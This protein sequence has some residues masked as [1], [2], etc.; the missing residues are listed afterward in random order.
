MSIYYI[1][2]IF[3]LISI[4]LFYIF[5]RKLVT[6]TKSMLD[7]NKLNYDANNICYCHPFSYAVTYPQPF[8]LPFSFPPFTCER[9]PYWIKSPSASSRTYFAPLNCLPLNFYPPIVSN[10]GQPNYT[11]IFNFPVPLLSLRSLCTLIKSAPFL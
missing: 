9:S 5:H 3:L 2:I 7:V 8:P 10:D 11:A 6:Q 4:S 1:F